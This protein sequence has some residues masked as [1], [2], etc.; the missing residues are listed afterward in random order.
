MS[1]L[2]V[3]N[4]S[5]GTDTVA[6]GYVVNGSAKAWVNFNGTGTVAIRDSVNVASVTDN[7]VGHYTVNISSNMLNGSYSMTGSAGTLNPSVAPSSCRPAAQF[8][9]S[10]CTFNTIYANTSTNTVGD[11]KQTSLT[12]HGDLA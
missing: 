2:N 12:I 1:T 9:S 10:A 8:T 7:G 3:A 6:T 11:Y 4:I 5:D